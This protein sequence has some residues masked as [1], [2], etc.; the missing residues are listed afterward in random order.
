MQP[1]EKKVLARRI[2]QID[3][4]IRRG[5]YTSAAKLSK[6]V[7]ASFGT[8]NCDLDGMRDFYCASLECDSIKQGW[9][10]TYPNHF[11]RHI[12]FEEGEVFGLILFYTLL[13]RYKN[14]PLEENLCSVLKK[15]GQAYR[16]RFPLI[17]DSCMVP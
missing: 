6:E 4:I 2:N 1:K 5:T 11:I 8:I 13:L 3:D 7:G 12:H 9:Y 17:Q 14:T 10:Y 15:S 16:I